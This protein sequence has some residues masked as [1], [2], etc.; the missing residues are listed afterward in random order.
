MN[1]L[2]EIMTQ[3]TAMDVSKTCIQTNDPDELSSLISKRFKK[4]TQFDVIPITMDEVQKEYEKVRK[5]DVIIT[6]KDNE[7][8]KTFL[9]LLG[10]P[11]IHAPGEAET[12]GSYMSVHN[13]IDGVYC[14]DTDVLAYGCKTMYCKPK[15]NSI[16][17]IQIDDVLNELEMTQHSFTDM[18]IMCGTD[19]N[20]NIPSVGPMNAYRLIKNYSDIDTIS[21]HTQY[22][23]SVLG[24]KKGRELFHIPSIKTVKRMISKSEKFRVTNNGQIEIGT[25]DSYELS[26]FLTMRDMYVDVDDLMSIWNN[27]N[28]CFLCHRMKDTMLCCKLCKRMYCEDTCDINKNNR[29]GICSGDIIEE[30]Q[31]AVKYDTKRLGAT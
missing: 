5:Q 24:H 1:D 22:N 28:R 31:L 7:D 2:L 4:L 23:C 30:I 3:M 21:T 6:K 18:C 15:G 14:E 19:Y 16:V 26:K 25:I 8:L 10:I 11:Y 17:R 12:L 20:D 27:P 29:C 13:M 9:R